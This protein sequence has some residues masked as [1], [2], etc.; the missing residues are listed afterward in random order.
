[1]MTR[2]YIPAPAS[3]PHVQL[4]VS[5]PVS[6]RVGRRRISYGRPLVDS[7]S[8]PTISHI[9][10]YSISQPVSTYDSRISLIFL[11]SWMF[12]YH[13]RI[14]LCLSSTAGTATPAAVP[15]TAAVHATLRPRA[16][17]CLLLWACLHCPEPIDGCTLDCV[18]V[19]APTLRECCSTGPLRDKAALSLRLL[20]LTLPAV[21]G[22]FSHLSFLP[23]LQHTQ[24]SDPCPVSPCAGSLCVYVP[25]SAIVAAETPVRDISDAT[26]SVP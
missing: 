4:F 15:L 26:A 13:A 11:A 24:Q 25:G 7:W 5:A 16:R 10:S 21:L 23:L 6:C 1:M 9:H 19:R 14:E 8:N 17:N 18:D 3:C 12:E 20:S 22:S 2:R